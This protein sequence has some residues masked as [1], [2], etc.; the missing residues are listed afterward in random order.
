MSGAESY[1]VRW[2]I[3]THYRAVLSKT[4]LADIAD[5][6]GIGEGYEDEIEFDGVEVDA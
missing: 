4:E 2:S 1:V 5:S 6:E 3:I